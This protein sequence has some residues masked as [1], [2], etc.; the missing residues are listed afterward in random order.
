MSKTY[1]FDVSEIVSPK[2]CSD[3]TNAQSTSLRLFVTAS[4]STRDR[5][6]VSCLYG[7]FRMESFTFKEQLYM[8]YKKQEKSTLGNELKQKK[9]ALN[10]KCC[11]IHCASLS[12]FWFSGISFFQIS[13]TAYEILHQAV[14]DAISQKH[15]CVILSARPG[16]MG[17]Q[18][19]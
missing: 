19:T 2:L 8:S 5:Q 12:L 10:S 15:S 4:L 9:I 1:P 3:I 13:N 16:R 6:N 14:S 7:G 17:L 11:L 18:V